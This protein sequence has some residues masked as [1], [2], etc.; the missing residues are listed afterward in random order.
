MQTIHETQSTGVPT[1][2]YLVFI[3]IM[4][5]STVGAALF[6]IS[7]SKVR[8]SDGTKISHFR[9]GGWVKE[10]W[11]I[12]TL[13]TDWKIVIMIPPFFAAELC[14]AL[15]GSINGMSGFCPL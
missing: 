3:I 15:Q 13:V 4:L 11:G 12:V 8:R 6:I 7:P 5:V 9:H 14:L 2:V 10:L 1:A